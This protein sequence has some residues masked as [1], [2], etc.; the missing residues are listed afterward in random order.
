[1]APGPVTAL[2]SANY[3]E[4]WKALEQ[5]VNA[6]RELEKRIDVRFEATEARM[7][8]WVGQLLDARSSELSRLRPVGRGTTVCESP[9]VTK[10]QAR[11]ANEHLDTH[12]I[13]EHHR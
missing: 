8:A 1:L 12:A 9:R 7:E 6:R 5:E 2:T 11:P 13:Q 3:P 10:G 4:L